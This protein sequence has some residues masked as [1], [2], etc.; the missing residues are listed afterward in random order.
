[1]LVGVGVF[2]IKTLGGGIKPTF[3][4]GDAGVSVQSLAAIRTGNKPVQIPQTEPEVFG[5]K[6]QYPVGYKMYRIQN[7]LG[8]VRDTKLD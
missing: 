3:A 6:T 1:M 7:A 4:G 2:A 5:V 8:R